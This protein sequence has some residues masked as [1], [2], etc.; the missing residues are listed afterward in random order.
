MTW[1]LS[2]I[3]AKAFDLQPF[4]QFYLHVTEIFDANDMNIGKQYVIT[5]LTLLQEAID[6]FT[7][8]G[9]SMQINKADIHKA[10]K[11]FIHDIFAKDRRDIIQDL[12]AATARGKRRLEDT[13][14]QRDICFF[15]NP[16]K[17]KTCPAGDKCERRHLD[18]T[19]PQT[20][21]TFNDA[22]KEYHNK[23]PKNH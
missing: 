17:G 8:S 4:L 10:P 1:G 15:H 3:A 12:V 16:S 21:A 13:K 5:R 22:L 14:P 20:L 18:T 6:T 11:D 19:K 23:R 7:N 2:H 9:A